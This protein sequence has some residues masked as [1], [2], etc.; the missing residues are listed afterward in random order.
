MTGD[1]RWEDLTPTQR[2]VL[3]ALPDDGHYLYVGHSRAI[4][5]LQ[6]E[7]LVESMREVASSRTARMARI[8]PAGRL[9]REGHR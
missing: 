7:G 4:A 6:R 1:A 9:L 2:K 5:A 3:L 8:T